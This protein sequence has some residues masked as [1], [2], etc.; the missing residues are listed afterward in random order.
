MALN[1]ENTINQLQSTT[2][3][4]AMIA[5]VVNVLALVTAFSGVAFDIDLI[6]T[7]M[8]FGLTG[9]SSVATI[10]LC[11]RSIKARISATEK[12]EPL[13]WLEAAKNMKKE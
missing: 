5:I 9:V 13:P 2:V 6:K 12:I 3:R 4:T 10:Y 1:E 7:V 11:W 8:E